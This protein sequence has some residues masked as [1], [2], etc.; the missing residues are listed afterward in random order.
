VYKH[1]LSTWSFFNRVSKHEHCIFDASIFRRRL[2]KQVTRKTQKRK[3]DNSP[4]RGR[5]R[6]GREAK[7]RKCGKLPQLI[8]RA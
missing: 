8:I 5:K 1:G 3:S 2:Y 4:G 7:F 6:G